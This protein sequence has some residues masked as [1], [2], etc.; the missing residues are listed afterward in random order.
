MLKLP[1]TL[2]LKFPSS[3]SKS[4][5]RCAGNAPGLCC[6]FSAL[7]S[8]RFLATVLHKERATWMIWCF[9]AFSQSLTLSF[10][11][12]FVLSGF[13][14]VCLSVCPALSLSLSLSLTYGLIH[15]GCATQCACKLEWFS[16]DVACVQCEHSLWQQVPFAYIALRVASCVLC[17]L[18]LYTHVPSSTFRDGLYL[19]VPTCTYSRGIPG[20][21]SL[22]IGICCPVTLSVLSSCLRP[23]LPGY[24]PHWN[25][26]APIQCREV[27]LLWLCSE[28][29]PGWSWMR[30]YRSEAVQLSLVTSRVLRMKLLPTQTPSSFVLAPAAE[31]QRVFP[32]WSLGPNFFLVQ[33][34][35][36]T[37]SSVVLTPASITGL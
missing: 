31:N 27:C 20:C 37:P 15:T 11:C 6:E 5:K 26:V 30:I 36:Q 17:D 25:R 16:F 13:S 33:V 7:N 9:F 10:L 19:T 8:L 1:W 2:R 32:I 34:L 21:L 12:M 29:L 28:K 14:S 23:S 22:C 18:G 3:F 24:L 35:A 4:Q